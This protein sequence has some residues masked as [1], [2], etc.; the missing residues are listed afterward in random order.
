MGVT[1]S[2]LIA[3]TDSV[4]GADTRAALLHLPWWTWAVI[5]AAG[6]VSLIEAD[7]KR[8]RKS[9]HRK[10]LRSSAW[11]ARR[12]AAL[13]RAEQKCQD[14]GRGGP[15][16]HVHHLTYKRW[17]REE[18]SDLRAL[19]SKCHARRHSPNRGLLDILIDRLRD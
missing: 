8:T 13:T 3:D 6:I 19:C 1:S 4:L 11:K 14:C 16:L 2:S 15:A 7:R 5:V 10:Y 17:G 12:R 9:T 18:P